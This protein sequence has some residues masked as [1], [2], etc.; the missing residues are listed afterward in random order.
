MLRSLNLQDGL[1]E[2]MAFIPTKRKC[3]EC[4]QTFADPSAF[5]AHRYAIG[6]CRSPEA[7][8]AAG[9]TMT[10]TGW[11]NIKSAIRRET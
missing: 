9:F 2:R 8:K 3:S 11:T 10:K 5:Y 6:R 1:R 7:L 4:K